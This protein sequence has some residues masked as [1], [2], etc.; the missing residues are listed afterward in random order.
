MV[1]GDLNNDTRLDLTVTNSG[2][3]TVSILLGYGDGSFVNQTTNPTGS[4]PV[5]V[6]VGDFNNDTRLDLVVANLNSFTVSI[7][8]GQSNLVFWYQ[9][10]LVTRNGSQPRAVVMEDFNNDS[11][12]D[13]AVADSGSHAIVIFFGYGNLSFSYS[14]EY[15]T[16]LNSTPYAI[17]AGDFNNDSHVD[18]VVANY[19]SNSIGVFVG[20]GNGSFADQATYSTGFGSGPMSVAV[21][22]LNEDGILDIAVVNYHT[23]SPGA[24]VGYG[25]GTFGPLIPFQFPYGSRPFFIGVADFNSDDKPDFAV[26]SKGTDSLSIL[27]QTC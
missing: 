27:L 24:F 21:A 15:S 18:I 8:L 9:T 22:D 5:S 10:S 14:T 16:G 4:V 11:R 3:N 20:H 19:Q 13:I 2:S 12:M 26:A 17:A 6:A 25:N 7:L 23:N 1:V